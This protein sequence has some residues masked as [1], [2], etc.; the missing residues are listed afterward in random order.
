MPVS[1]EDVLTDRSFSQDLVGVYF[2]IPVTWHVAIF[3]SM[4]TYIYNTASHKIKW[5]WKSPIAWWRHSQ[6]SWGRAKHDSRMCCL[7]TL[8]ELTIT[9]KCSTYSYVRTI[10]FH[11][12]KKWLG[13]WFMNLLYIIFGCPSNLV[14]KMFVGVMVHAYNPSTWEAEARGS[15]VQGLP[16]LQSK[17]LS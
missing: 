6:L 15:G 9:E 1:I 5:S 16:G 8:T 14:K 13:S 12:D 10:I 4:T 2:I 7:N 11:R 3:E 17:T